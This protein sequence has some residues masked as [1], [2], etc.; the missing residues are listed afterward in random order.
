MSLIGL[1][2]QEVRRTR[3]PRGGLEGM[4]PEAPEPPAA[5][6]SALKQLIDF[7]PTETIALFWLAVPA[8]A[9]LTEYQSGKKPSGATALDWW[10]YFGLLA[11]TPVLLV[12]SYLSGLAAA[13]AARP[14]A[15]DWPWWKAV[16]ATVAFA[17][18]AFAVPGNPF[19]RDAPLLMAAWVVATVVSTLLVLLDPI[20]IHWIRRPPGS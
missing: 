6:Q 8:A 20:V 16:A 19:L 5:A 12:L 14:P 7:I 3:R 4:G 9:A 10:V 17:A 15:R 13:G 1:A 11:F 18:W 2:D